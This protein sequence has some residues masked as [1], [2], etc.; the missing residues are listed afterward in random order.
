MVNVLKSGYYESHL[1]YDNV[2]WFVDE[3]IKLAN[4]LPFYFKNTDK[5]IIITREDDKEYRKNYIYRFCE[6]ELIIDK[7][8]DHCHLTGN[9]SGPA[10]DIIA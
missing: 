4:K 6:K 10:H 1:G 5:Y 9:H 7:F 8:R 3:V 2:E